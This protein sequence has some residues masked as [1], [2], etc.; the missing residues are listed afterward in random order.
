MKKAISILGTAAA[1]YLLSTRGRTGQPGLEKFRGWAYAH[2]GL[3]GEGRPEN[4]LAA[5]RAAVERGYGAELDVHLLKDGSLAVIHD[6]SLKRTTGKEGRVEELTAAALKD[7]TLEGTQET[8]P[9]FSDVLKLFER[10]AP[11][12]VELKVENNCGALCSAVAELLD[13]YG[14]DYCVESFD[15]RAVAWFRKHRPQVIRGQ[16]MENYFATGAKLPSVLKLLLTNHIVNFLTG[17]D[18]VACRY[19]DLGLY[20]NAVARGLWKMAGAAWTIKTQAEFDDARNKGWIPIF[21]G[22]EP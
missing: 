12:I 13:G 7:H 15:P 3:H 5:F 8:I 21:E 18:F 16:L 17:A 6:S 19:Q 4:S 11:L 22:F 9:L 20:A 1:A 14:G 10:K 2:R